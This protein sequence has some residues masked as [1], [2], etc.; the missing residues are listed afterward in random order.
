MGSPG[1]LTHTASSMQVTPGTAPMAGAAIL[2][3]WGLQVGAAQ[4]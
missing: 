4:G 1:L 3:H 2:H